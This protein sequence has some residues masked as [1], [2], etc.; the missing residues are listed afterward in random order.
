[1]GEDFTVRTRP[2]INSRLWCKVVLN[3]GYVCEPIAYIF[4][5]LASK[6]PNK[7]VKDCG[8]GE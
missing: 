1:M 7:S 2:R 4:L 3:K 8:R 5:E 6:K